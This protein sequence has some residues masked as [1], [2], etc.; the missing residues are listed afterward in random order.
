MLIRQI[1]GLDGIR[2]ANLLDSAIMSPF[3][4]FAD[5]DLY[6]DMLAKAARLGFQLINNHAFLDGNKRIGILAMLT[7][8]EINNIH[9]N[10]T[11]EELISLGL[12]IA[13]GTIDYN[14]VRLWLE[15]HCESQ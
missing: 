15:M 10:C 6:P 1:G 13:D 11:D 7:F 5:T 8:L 14:N 12:G 2:D 9:I 3:Q 4:T